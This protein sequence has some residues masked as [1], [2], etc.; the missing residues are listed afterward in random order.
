MLASYAYDAPCCAHEEEE[1]DTAH[2][3]IYLVLDN[4]LAPRTTQIVQEIVQIEGTIEV[5]F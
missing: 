1:L 4:T 5:S 2:S 3:S